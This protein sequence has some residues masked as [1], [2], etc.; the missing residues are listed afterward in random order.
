MKRLRLGGLTITDTGLVKLAEGCPS[1]EDVS[2]L[3]CR[4]VTYQGVASLAKLCPSLH[5]LR[6]PPPNVTSAERAF[7]V[8][9]YPDINLG[10]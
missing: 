9:V 5:V 8:A 3:G 2:L 7:F 4:S 10:Y 1:L 6:L